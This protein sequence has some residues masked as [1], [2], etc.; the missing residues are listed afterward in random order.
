MA[1]PTGQTG[2]GIYPRQIVIMVTE[3]IADR[4][5]A[6]AKRHRLSKSEVTRTYIEAG[7]ELADQAL[8]AAG[9]PPR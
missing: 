5:E 1:S 3:E 2:K 9:G 8:A 6:E 4:L 7:V